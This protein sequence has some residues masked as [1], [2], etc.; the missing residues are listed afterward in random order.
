MRP[1]Q[2]II[3]AIFGVLAIAGLFL[4]ANFSGSGSS[5]TAVGNVLIWGT[6]PEEA[7]QAGIDELVGSN[8]DFVGVSYEER[9]EQT[10]DTDLAEAIASGEGPDLILISQE[11][12]H[13]Q[14]NK[15]VVVPFKSIPE[16]TYRDNYLPIFE[17]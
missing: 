8:K 10:F 11:Q 17:L 4:F 7:V 3:M 2:I 1:F 16:R 9:S 13:P 15:L 5:S 6:L 12:L 14:K